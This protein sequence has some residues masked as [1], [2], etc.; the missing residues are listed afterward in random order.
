MPDPSTFALDERLAADSVAVTGL[1]LCSVRLMDD[2]RYPWLLLVPRVAGAVEILDLEETDQRRLYDEVLRCARALQ[3]V[4]RPDKLNIAALGNQVPQLHLHVVA[5][6]RSDD[7]WPRPVW[8]VHP[9][10]PYAADA[11][12]RLVAELAAAIERA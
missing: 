12:H 9:A 7:A 4:V 8:G 3:A 6:F 1:P 2:S 10:E 11:R 5:R